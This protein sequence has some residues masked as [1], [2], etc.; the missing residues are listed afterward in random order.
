[1]TKLARSRN[2]NVINTAFKIKQN[3]LMAEFFYLLLAKIDILYETAATLNLTN[4]AINCMLNNKNIFYGNQNGI[5]RT[6]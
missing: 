2:N 6:R 3:E 5:Y 1:M 4:P